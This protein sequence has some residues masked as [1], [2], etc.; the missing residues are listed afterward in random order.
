MIQSRPATS[1][2]SPDHT[3]RSGLFSLPPAA[4]EMLGEALA[5]DAGLVPDPRASGVVGSTQ[6]LLWEICEQLRLW[7]DD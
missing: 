6:E 5:D 1:R 3:H 4:L 2:Q 7:P